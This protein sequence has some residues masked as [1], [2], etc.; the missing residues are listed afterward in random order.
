MP[1]RWGEDLDVTVIRKY[2]GKME[3]K[4]DATDIYKYA[5]MVE[6]VRDAMVIRFV[7]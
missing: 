5:F 6:M 2:A 4:S 3:K 7:S 1:A